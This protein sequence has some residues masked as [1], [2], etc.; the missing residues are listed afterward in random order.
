MSWYW[1]FVKRMYDLKHHFQGFFD[2]YFHLMVSIVHDTKCLAHREKKNVVTLLFR[3]HLLC[4]WLT[5]FVG[6]FSFSLFLTLQI[7]Y[8]CAHLYFHETGAK[9]SF[10]HILHA[11]FSCW[12]ICWVLSLSSLS[13]SA[14]LSMKCSVC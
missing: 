9:S 10:E 14:A 11:G 8:V 1:K 3:T 4:Q 2:T 7:I 12:W 13:C 6:N 5:F